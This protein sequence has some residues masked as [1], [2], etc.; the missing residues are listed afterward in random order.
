M[1]SKLSQYE[2]ASVSIFINCES[3]GINTFI[4]LLHLAN[5]DSSKISNSDGIFISVKD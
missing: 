1:F 2:N 3:S 5:T 4:K